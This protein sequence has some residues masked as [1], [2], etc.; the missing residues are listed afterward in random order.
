MILGF[1]TLFI[2]SVNQEASFPG[3]F[4]S[5]EE[6]NAI[7][8]LKPEE[9]FKSLRHCLLTRTCNIFLMDG[10]S[11]DDQEWALVD[12]EAEMNLKGFVS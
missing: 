5:R 12:K 2:Y 6:K 1:T 3:Q 7:M 8:L 10:E 11:R 9:R 4:Y